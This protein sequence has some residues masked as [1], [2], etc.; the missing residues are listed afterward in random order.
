MKDEF[1]VITDLVETPRAQDNHIA[2]PFS[3]N[4]KHVRGD[5]VPYQFR[6]KM[7]SFPHVLRLPPAAWVCQVILSIYIDKNEADQASLLRDKRPKISMAEHVH[8]YFKNTL[9]LASAADAQVAQLLASCEVYMIKFRRIALFASQLGLHDKEN[10]PNLDVRDSGFILSI[11]N[12]L[13]KLGELVSEKSSSKKKISKTSSVVIKP[14]ILRSAAVTTL[15][16]IFDKWLPDG[17]HD[18]VLKVKAMPSTERGLKYIDLDDY[19]ELLI[20]PWHTVRLTWED[21]LSF[22]FHENCTVHRVLSEAQFANDAGMREKDTIVSQLSKSSATDCTRRRLRLFQK[23]EAQD[24]N[25]D[26]SA[27]VLRRAP[28]KASNSA[29]EP[30]CELMNRKTFINTVSTLNPSLRY[31]EVSSLFHSGQIF[32][33]F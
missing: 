26:D 1:G 4:T 12:N 27:A 17:G 24:H 7:T 28:G 22:T 32:D 15:Q 5:N 20:E 6:G 19:V 14:D 29:K 10:P 25:S 23:K 13:I 30:I 31:D 2:P 16:S 21:H 18:Y 11:I 3:A 9:G 33:N 8:N